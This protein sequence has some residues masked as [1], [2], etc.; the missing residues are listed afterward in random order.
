[1]ASRKA[2]KSPQSAR[3]RW[4]QR[5][6]DHREGKSDGKRN[7]PAY[8]DVEIADQSR[9]TNPVMM[10][11]YV[12][13]IVGEFEAMGRTL[14]HDFSQAVRNLRSEQA[15]IRAKIR[16]AERD[17]DACEKDIDR[18]NGPLEGHERH[19]ANPYDLTRDPALTQASRYAQRAVKIKKLRQAQ[20]AH[21]QRI[22][23][24]ESEHDAVEAEVGNVRSSFSQRARRER[25]L[26]KQRVRTYWRGVTRTHRLGRH[27]G[28]IMNKWEP[29]IPLPPWVEPETDPPEAGPDG[30]HATTSDPKE[31]R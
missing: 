19:P 15:L 10:S 13:T 3:Y 23:K 28:P 20:D 11:T 25:N 14:Y 27:L 17:I 29:E 30:R 2:G 21:K 12:G 31:H 4:W 1:M 26:A 8:T 16:S 22:S 24:H 7:T 18:L 5:W 9:T 6:R